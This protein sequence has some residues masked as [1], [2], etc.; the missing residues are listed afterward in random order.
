MAMGSVKEWWWF[1][2]WELGEV[3]LFEVW[4][5]WARGSQVQWDQT[6]QPLR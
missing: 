1:S 4:E 3:L 5:E 6:L 2:S